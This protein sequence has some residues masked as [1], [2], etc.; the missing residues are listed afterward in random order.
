IQQRQQRTRGPVPMDVDQLA[1]RR[2][3]RPDGDEPRDPFVQA[4]PTVW[5]A[6]IYRPVVGVH[7][8]QFHRPVVG[9]FGDLVKQVDRALAPQTP[10]SS[11][12]SSA[13]SS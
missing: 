7:H 2:V 11:T 10:A 5:H 1:G 6:R 9:D 3:G 8:E 4:A 13:P 12:T